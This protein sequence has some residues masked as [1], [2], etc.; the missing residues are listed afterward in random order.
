MLHISFYNL[1]VSGFSGGTILPATFVGSVGPNESIDD[2]ARRALAVNG[3]VTGAA[4]PRLGGVVGRSATATGIT[5]R[6]A[7]FTA[8]ASSAAAA[9]AADNAL[10]ARR[11]IGG[12]AVRRV[13]TAGGR[14]SGAATTVRRTATAVRVPAGSR[15]TTTTVR[16]TI[17]GQ[18][19][20]GT[21]ASAAATRR[22]TTVTTQN[23]SRRPNMGSRMAGV[24]RGTSINRS[25][26]VRLPTNIDI[27]NLPALDIG[28]VG[29]TGSSIASSSSS[30]SSSSVLSS[31]STTNRGGMQDARNPNSDV[32]VERTTITRTTNLVDQ[33]SS[34]TRDLTAM[35]RQLLGAAAS[36]RPVFAI[37][38]M[39]ERANAADLQNIMENIAS[40]EYY[41][42]LIKYRRFG[43]FI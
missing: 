37:I 25:A 8:G 5:G 1:G 32:T 34:A 2:I 14:P 12:T 7:V 31:S 35:E 38:P 9:A 40:C 24:T 27:N 39:N 22:V 36:D 17:T 18:G 11:S 3:R 43:I 15:G 28:M 33:P 13:S 29:D 41:S 16:R 26:N 4:G 6:S 21:A 23:G 42:S 20:P 10:L 30:S 19:R